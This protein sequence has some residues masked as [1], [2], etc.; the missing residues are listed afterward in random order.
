MYVASSMV[1]N[2]VKEPL[3]AKLDSSS[4]LKKYLYKKIFLALVFLEILSGIINLYY[5]SLI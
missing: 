4:L 3:T 2:F 1:P 5:T